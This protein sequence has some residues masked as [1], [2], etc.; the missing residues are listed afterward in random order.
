MFWLIGLAISIAASFIGY[1]IARDF[2]TRKLRFVNAVHSLKAPI[3][4]GLAGV[5]LAMPVAWLLPLIGTGTA[6]AFGISVGMGVT[7]GAR[8][9]RR[10]NGY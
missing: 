9:I 1:S 8:D 4:A 2:T 10:L 7:A 5:L 3:L 6:V